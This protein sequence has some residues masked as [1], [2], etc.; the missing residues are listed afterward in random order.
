MRPHLCNG[1]AASGGDGLRQ[2][3][4]VGLGGSAS[5][6]QG[7]SQRSTSGLGVAVLAGN[8]DGLSQSLGHSLTVLQF[9]RN[10]ME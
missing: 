2:G 1:A 7:L 3:G 9:Q 5:R 10:K 4:G 8:G 6:S